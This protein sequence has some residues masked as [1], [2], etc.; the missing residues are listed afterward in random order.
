VVNASVIDAGEDR[1]V[2][3]SALNHFLFCE[4]RAGLIHVEG[5]FLENEHTVVGE[6][7]HEQAD[8]R[9]YEVA[10][11]VTLLRALPVFSD[12]LGLSGRCDIVERDTAGILHPVEYKKGPKRR[13]TNDDAQLC[14]QA[15]C[16][17]EMFGG[18]VQSGSIYH[19]ASKRRRVV[20]F[21]P[22]LRAL[23]ENAVARLHLLLANRIVSAAVLK[24]ACQ[25]CSLHG[26]CLPELT[27]EPEAALRRVARQLEV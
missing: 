5:I 24:P 16:L 25:E 18:E 15:L 7:V 23:T 27:A 2:P 12:R 17:E 21:S 14:A 26:V 1:R 10:R 8:L 22:T 3:L 19:A 9:G 4:R 6:L 11:G 20:Q 13:F